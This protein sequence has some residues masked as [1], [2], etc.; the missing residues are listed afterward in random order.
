MKEVSNLRVIMTDLG[1]ILLIIGL[2]IALAGLVLMVVGKIPLP[3]LGR[4]P[5]DFIFKRRNFTFYFP[6]ATSLLISL[7]L[8][9]ILWLIGR[10]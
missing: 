9:L 5:G 1:K 6:L 4:L 3:W 7:V 8:T 2:L 10:K